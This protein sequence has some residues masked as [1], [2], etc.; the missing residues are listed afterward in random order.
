METTSDRAHPFRY[1][2][3]IILILI[4]SLA[5]F[6]WLLHPPMGELGLMALFLSITAVISAI[7]G[8][9]AFRM[10]W[11]DRSPSLHLT[12]MGIYAIASVLAFFNVWV[13]AKL[14]FTSPH[15]LML[16]TVLLLFAGGIAMVLGYYL[17]N[18]LISRIR[19]LERT[20]KAIQEGN[21]MVQTPVLGSDELAALAQT[22]NQMANRL[23][24][25]DQK[26]R[27][28]DELRRDLIAWAGHDLQTPLA[29]MRAIVEALADG[30]VDDP[31]TIQRYLRT[32]QRNIQDLSL[33][34]DDLFQIAQLD[35]GGMRLNLE[36]ASI[37]D[38]V[39]DTLESFS[40]LAT[41]QGIK[42]EGTVTAGVDTIT[43][44]VQRI[45]RVLNNLIRNAFQHTPAGG[46]VMVQV[47]PLSDG[48]QVEVSDTG[49][50][51]PAEDLP[52]IFD[53]FYRSE[54]SRSRSTGGAG[55]G[56]AIV[57]GIVEAHGGTIKVESSPGKGSR[58][59]FNLPSST[60]PDRS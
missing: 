34:I 55:L 3:G 35:A 8:F 60:R 38:L 33:L 12:L 1:L 44:D 29:S 2:A 58:F 5:L 14:M 45:G 47:Q 9:A 30:V 32:A 40:E 26:Q 31:A 18:A 54:K 16:A 56:L 25:A 36:L 27:Q 20:A 22:F 24:E 23:R 50:G 59:R 53:R 10:G 41:Q 28:L 21:L 49:E 48:I 39:S 17:S 13:T 42:L 46:S 11:M 43:M 19:T 57:K 15:D 6:Y 51:I 52:Y 7:A 4:S 37:S